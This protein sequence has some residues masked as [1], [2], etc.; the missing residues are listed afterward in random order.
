M[1]TVQRTGWVGWGRFAAV[2]VL[3]NGIFGVLQG[4][5]A[6]FAPDPYY[7]LARGHL[8]LFDVSGWGWWT[9]IIGI[10]MILTG[11]ALFTGATWARV[12]TIVLVII[13]AIGQMLLIP[14]QP[15]WASITIGIDILIIYALTAHGRELRPDA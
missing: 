6:L 15:W 11:A 1:S 3:V 2:I 7:V 5:V 4:I 14:A 9:L 8:F 13:G 12:I 10:L